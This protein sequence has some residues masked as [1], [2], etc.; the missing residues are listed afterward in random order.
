M[1]SSNDIF[2]PDL[3]LI[4]TYNDYGKIYKLN[5]TKNLKTKVTLCSDGWN[6]FRVNVNFDLKCNANF[7]YFPFD[8]KTCTIKFINNNKIFEDVS[9]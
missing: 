3:R 8:K 4:S 6:L 5:A 1:L 2:V 7:Y 9:F